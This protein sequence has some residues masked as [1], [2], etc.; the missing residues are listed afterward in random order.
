MNRIGATASMAKGIAIA[1]VSNGLR[2]ILIAGHEI[3][4]L[5]ITGTVINN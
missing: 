1:K 5:D 3:T 4:W 2:N